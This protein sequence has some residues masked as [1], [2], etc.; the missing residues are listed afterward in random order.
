MNQMIGKLTTDVLH[1]FSKRLHDLAITQVEHSLIITLVL[2]QPDPHLRDQESIHVINHCYM[3]ALYIQLCSTRSE[4]EAKMLFDNILEV[5]I[6]M[7]NKII[8]F[9][10]LF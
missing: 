6:Y 2:C 8:G 10:F 1:E 5:V 3:Y 4:K 7:L 9:Y